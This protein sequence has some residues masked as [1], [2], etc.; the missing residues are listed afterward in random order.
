MNTVCGFP[1]ISAAT[2]CTWVVWVHDMCRFTS[3]LRWIVSIGLRCITLHHG[4]LSV[5]KL[6]LYVALFDFLSTRLVH[7]V[8]H[9]K[10]MNAP[11]YSLSVVTVCYVCSWW[12]TVLCWRRRLLAATW[13]NLSCMVAA[14]HSSFYWMLSSTASLLNI[15]KLDVSLS[16][17][18]YM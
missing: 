14:P 3:H 17:H 18:A 10:C 16:L 4:H 6:D 11:S 15:L 9:N 1:P 7:S 8:Q 5:S 2:F 13:G 12:V